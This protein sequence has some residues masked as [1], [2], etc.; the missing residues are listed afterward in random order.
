MIFFS[1]EKSMS[2]SDSSSELIKSPFDQSPIL[3]PG[4]L[5]SPQ[6]Q[7]SCDKENAIPPSYY[8]P[9]LNIIKRTKSSPFKE[10]Q[11][12]VNRNLNF[13]PMKRHATPKKNVVSPIKYSPVEDFDTNSQ[14]SGFCG[15]NRKESARK[16]E[17]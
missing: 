11:N 15:S 9:S 7:S 3:S 13:S 8:S 16:L 10:L 6:R 14:D 17:R 4:L 12:T 1:A 2:S 5:L